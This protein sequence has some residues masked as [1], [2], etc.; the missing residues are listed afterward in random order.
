MSLIS[1]DEAVEMLKEFVEKNGVKNL[2]V[3]GSFFYWIL[4]DNLLTLLR[5]WD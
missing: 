1:L 5:W 3:A 2:N 4:K